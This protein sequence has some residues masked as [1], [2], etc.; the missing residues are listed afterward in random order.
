[1]KKYISFIVLLLFVKS[2]WTQNTNLDFKGAIK[3][4]NQVTIID[5]PVY[6]T[7]KT[8]YDLQY[9]NGSYQILHP[10]FAVQ[11]KTKKNNFHEIELT[12]FSFTSGFSVTASV[13]YE[14]IVNLY[15][16]K[17]WKFV[18]SLGF[19]FNPYYLQSD[20][21]PGDEQTSSY[22]SSDKFF[23]AKFLVTPRLTYYCGK[24]LFIDLNVPLCVFNPYMESYT[25]EDPTLPLEER[26]TNSTSFAGVFPGFFTVRLG[27][28]LKF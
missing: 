10:T 22:K 27:I 18:P 2:G 28:G 17:N 20:T 15:K 1:M 6:K 21:I 16:S 12:D 14:Y 23:G 8:L 4:Q 3:F 11:W 24:K 5:R 9:R 19:A 25:T 7:D 13:R 26:T